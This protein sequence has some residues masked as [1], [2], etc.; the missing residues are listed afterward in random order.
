MSYSNLHRRPT[1]LRSDLLSHG[2]WLIDDPRISHSFYLFTFYEDSLAASSKEEII[3]ALHHH[4]GGWALEGGDVMGGW[5]YGEI[6]ISR[7]DLIGR[8]SI[9]QEK[10]KNFSKSNIYYE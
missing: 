1:P 2:D 8:N 9:Y 4:A 3:A 6:W 5:R 10:E 7:W